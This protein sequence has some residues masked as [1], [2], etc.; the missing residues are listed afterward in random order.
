MV[1]TAEEP[2][3]CA[4]LTLAKDAV[5]R[6]GRLSHLEIG[7]S[8][9]LGGFF[10][11][12]LPEKVP[13]AIRKT[14]AL[15]ELAMDNDP[16]E[17]D[18]PP[19][20][21]T[22][23][24]GLPVGKEARCKLLEELARRPEDAEAVK[25]RR[26]AVELEEHMD[27]IHKAWVSRRR[28]VWE[29]LREAELLASERFYRYLMANLE[30]VRRERER[31][32]RDANFT[33]SELWKAAAR[34]HEAREKF[35]VDELKTAAGVIDGVALLVTLGAIAGSIVRGDLIDDLARRQVA[36]A[37]WFQGI[38]RRQ[39]MES[40]TEYLTV[41]RKE[42]ERFP[43]L[44]V[45]DHRNVQRVAEQQKEDVLEQL[46]QAED[47]ISELCREGVNAT[48]VSESFEDKLADMAERIADGSRICVWKLPFFID[49]AMDDMSPREA[50]AVRCM[51]GFAA[52]VESG[53]A[54]RNGIIL[55]SVEVAMLVA[56]FA[57]PVGVGVA[58]MWAV[59]RLMRTVHE[60]DQLDALFKASLDRSFLLPESEHDPASKMWIIFDVLGLLVWP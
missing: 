50:N 30:V 27:W 33:V 14:Q 21:K 39:L 10:A 11:F 15:F 56:V 38:A 59:T 25:L 12:P 8:L 45:M 49:Q 53:N 42:A 28:E 24:G 46:K 20:V 47:A 43:V 55:G 36:Q 34:V 18:E 23:F 3:G 44:F 6:D 35:E 2:G 52:E 48:T 7:A 31:Y 58:L 60:Y 51:R 17:L 9:C 1:A 54:I 16:R 41:L 37:S 19:V 4:G 26:A 5:K 57:G 40:V 32:E 13:D 29:A 22:H